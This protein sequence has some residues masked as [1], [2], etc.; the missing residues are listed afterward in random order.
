[1]WLDTVRTH[2]SRVG[3]RSMCGRLRLW[4]MALLA[5]CFALPAQCLTLSPGAAWAGIFA[6]ATSDYQI[7]VSGD[8]NSRVLLSWRL[9][10]KGRTL[11][12][13]REEARF[14]DTESLIVGLPLQTPPLKR[15]ISL[16]ARLIVEAEDSVDP[17]NQARFEI[18]IRIYGPDP[19]LS[20]PVFEAGLNIQLFDPAGGT[21]RML[22]ALNM[23]YEVLSKSR[24]L[25]ANA[26]GFGIV[27][28]GVALDQQR[29]LVPTLLE[30][31]QAGR[32]VLVLQPTSGSIPVPTLPAALGTQPSALSF[33][34]ASVTQ[35]FAADHRWA[36][37]LAEE[38]KGISLQ[39]YRDSISA[40]ITGS[41]ESRWTWMKVDF[42][43]SGGTLIVCTLPFVNTFDA[44]PIPQIIFGRLV[45]FAGGHSTQHPN[46]LT[47]K[48][49]QP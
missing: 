6:G 47:E 10:A 17:N 8:R 49:R 44:G 2:Q 27:G 19:L 22:E 42:E 34:T 39:T 14:A 21:G 5:S 3:R 38:T 11:A 12:S 32:R 33:A 9:H 40:A 23:P 41:D 25:D 48:E 4:S 30:Q 20:D 7:V 36:A 24:F 35:L 16:T 31:V 26:K 45:A 28:A 43:H 37:D 13:G 46:L 1:M 15:G 29:G 18:P